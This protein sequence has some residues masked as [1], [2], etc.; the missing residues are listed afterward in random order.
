MKR[1]LISRG[2]VVV[3]A[4]LAVIGLGAG[5][6]SATGTQHRRQAR[7]H[8]V[9]ATG[10]WSDPGATITGITPQGSDY[11]VDFVGSTSTAGDLL[12]QSRYTMHV[13]YDPVANTSTGSVDETFSATL[14]NR[15][16]GT[17]TLAEH[18]SVKGDGSL[19]VTGYV[20]SGT[21]IFRGA[22][23]LDVFTGTTDPSGTGPSAGSYVMVFDLA[24]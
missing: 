8:L 3:S 10:T 9:L 16:S 19:L 1:T 20:V 7:H 4:C 23:G 14:P 13:V 17:F 18:V 5:P 22:N 2:L 6:V 21:G 11:L 15:G 24:G 12:G